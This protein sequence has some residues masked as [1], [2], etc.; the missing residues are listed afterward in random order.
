MRYPHPSRAIMFD[1][2]FENRMH[3]LARTYRASIE[4]SDLC[5]TYNQQKIIQNWASSKEF[6]GMQ[7][8]ERTERFETLVGLKSLAEDVM[9]HGGR[10]FDISNLADQFKSNSLVGRQF[11]K[12]RLPFETIFVSFGKRRELAVDADEDIFFE[13]AYVRQTVEY[14]ELLFDVALVCNDPKFVNEDQNIGDMLKGLTR[15]YHQKI[16]LGKPLEAATNSV[17]YALDPSVLGDRS[18]AVAGTRLVAHTILYLSQ[19]KIEAVF[20]HDAAAPKKMAQRAAMGEYG[21]QPEL[22]WRGYP[23]VTYLGHKPVRAVEVH[24]QHHLKM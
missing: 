22:D 21:V 19:P 12:E 23:S 8:D 15:F 4:N 3:E 10:L 14:G 11:E 18:A 6:A 7:P 2:L 5:N 9:L 1:T 16:P 20:G 13:G 24:Q 17:S